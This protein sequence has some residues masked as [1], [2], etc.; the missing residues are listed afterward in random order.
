[1]GGGDRLPSGNPW[2]RLPSYFIKKIIH[3]IYIEKYITPTF[4]HLCHGVARRGKSSFAYSGA[5]RRLNMI[6]I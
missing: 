6:I 5:F 1:M 4:T 2:A 3:I